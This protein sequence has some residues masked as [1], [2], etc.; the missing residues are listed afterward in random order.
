MNIDALAL[1]HEMMK[2][3]WIDR[4]EN[5]LLWSHSE[6][7]DVRDELDQIGKE[8]G[9][10]VLQA[11][12]RIWCPLRTMICFLKTTLIFVQISEQQTM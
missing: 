9:F 4:N 12:D 11:Q 7:S 5:S 8:L 6:D 10:E 3:G 2:K 1:F